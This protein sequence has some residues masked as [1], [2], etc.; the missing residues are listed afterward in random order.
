MHQNGEREREWKGRVH[1]IVYCTVP[2]LSVKTA[3]CMKKEREEGQKEGVNV[4]VKKRG[5]EENRIR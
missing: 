2:Y 3:C 4:G 1:K 5:V